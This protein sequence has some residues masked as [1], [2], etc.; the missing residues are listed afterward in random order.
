MWILVSLRV[1]GIESH[2]IY[3]FKNR[4]NRTVE[5]EFNK[6]FRDVDHT[7]ISFRGQF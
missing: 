3:P 2:Y 7:E 4:F 1:F 6:K 5:K